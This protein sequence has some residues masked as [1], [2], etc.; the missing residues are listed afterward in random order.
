MTQSFSELLE[1]RKR[2]LIVNYSSTFS[3]YK[4]DGASEYSFYLMK[5]KYALLQNNK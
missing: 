5:A 3:G 4:P 1:K 2:N